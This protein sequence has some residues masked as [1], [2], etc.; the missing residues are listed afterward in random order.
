MELK[1]TLAVYRVEVHVSWKE[2]AG[3]LPCIPM[4]YWSLNALWNL[5][6][7][8]ETDEFY[9]I[10]LG[11]VPKMYESNVAYGSWYTLFVCSCPV[12]CEEWKYVLFVRGFTLM[13]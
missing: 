10:L 7:M 1:S 12:I 13:L 4:A 11:Y 6:D 5:Y 2:L 8:S 3:L 9:H